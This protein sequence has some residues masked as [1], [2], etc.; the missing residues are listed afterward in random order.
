MYNL[1]IRKKKS[2][3]EYQIEIGKSKNNS[4]LSF[5]DFDE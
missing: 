1:A 2:A 4:F 5:T 3:Q